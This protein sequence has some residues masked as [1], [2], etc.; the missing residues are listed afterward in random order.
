M[1]INSIISRSR[2]P[3]IRGPGDVFS[4]ILIQYN[5]TAS[6][7]I[8]IRNLKI[9]SDIKCLELSLKSYKYLVLRAKYSFRSF[10]KLGE[11]CLLAFG[12]MSANSTI[13]SSFSTLII[14]AKKLGNIKKIGLKVRPVDQRHIYTNVHSL[15][16]YT[17]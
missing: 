7:V 12:I 2:Q 10:S 13:Y 8:L 3:I 1:I 11:L 6:L 15:C 17:Y 14:S 16:L 4:I 9:Y 5:R